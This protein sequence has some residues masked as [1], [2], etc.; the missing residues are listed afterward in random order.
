MRRLHRPPTSLLDK[1]HGDAILDLYTA[2]V[3]V[4]G[5]EVAHGR[6]SGIARSDDGELDVHLRLPSELGGEGGG[7]NPEQLLAAGY[8]ACFHG[9]LSLLAAR[10][11]LQ[12][13]DAT[14]TASVTFGRDPIDGQFL[15]TSDIRVLLPGVDRA[16]AEELIRGTERSCPYTKLFRQG[17]ESVVALEA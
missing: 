5:G 13:P 8:A 7:T 11:G 4:T 15:L 17:M 16:V 14:V 6:A 10:H 9:A 1:F 3:L 2:S 12:I